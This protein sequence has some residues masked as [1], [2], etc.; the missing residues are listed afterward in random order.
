MVRF[1]HSKNPK[2]EENRQKASDTGEVKY[3]LKG[4]HRDF[5]SGAALGQIALEVHIFYRSQGEILLLPNALVMKT[6]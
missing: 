6:K 3:K 4:E 5:H 2:A 1:S